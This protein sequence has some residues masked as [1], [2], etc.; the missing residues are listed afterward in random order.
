LVIQIF[1]DTFLFVLYF[2]P[3]LRIQSSSANLGK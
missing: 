1:H 2:M 3:L